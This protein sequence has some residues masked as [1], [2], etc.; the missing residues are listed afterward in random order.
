MAGRNAHQAVVHGCTHG[1]TQGHAEGPAK[2][3][4]IRRRAGGQGD[5]VEEQ[6]DLRTFTQ[7]RC[8]HDQGQG[9]QRALSRYHVLAQRIH[10]LRHVASFPR[11]PDVMA[12]EHEHRHC[13]DR[14]V[15]QLLASAGHGIGDRF[16]EQC[17]QPGADDA[18]DNAAAHPQASAWHAAGCAQHDA[19]H[20]SGFNDFTKNDDECG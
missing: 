8:A 12:S 5:A 15:E 9:H 10:F 13:H 11:H 7:H 14:G 2:E 6:H 20:Q 1:R 19:E 16:C 17:H 4:R 18:A 3:H